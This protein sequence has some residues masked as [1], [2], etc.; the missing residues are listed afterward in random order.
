M[1][2]RLLNYNDKGNLVEEITIFFSVSD[3]ESQF[4]NLIKL[5]FFSNFI[6][7]NLLNSIIIKHKILIFEQ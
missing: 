5:N 3:L 6:T 1:L 2:H 7:Y 4:N